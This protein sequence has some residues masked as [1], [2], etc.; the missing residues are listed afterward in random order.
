MLLFN[1]WL[2]SIAFHKLMIKIFTLCSLQFLAQ[3]IFGDN[4]L[5][6]FCI[7]NLVVLTW[8]KKQWEPPA[9]STQGNLSKKPHAARC[10]RIA[11]LCNTVAQPCCLD[12]T[13]IDTSDKTEM[14]SLLYSFLG[15]PLLLS[16]RSTKFRFLLFTLRGLHDVPA[17]NELLK[18]IAVHMSLTWLRRQSCLYHSQNDQ[19]QKNISSLFY[20]FIV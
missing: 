13:I 15:L 4:S 19:R 17:V 3:L 10:Y 12:Y 20:F 18:R 5:H 16:H 14:G 8:T 6:H 2:K 7:E 1:L 9:Q 11:Y